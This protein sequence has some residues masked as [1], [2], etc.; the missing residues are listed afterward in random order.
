MTTFG[1]QASATVTLKPTATPTPTPTTTAATTWRFVNL[2]FGVDPFDSRHSLIYGEVINASGVAQEI[3]DFTGTF[4][5]AQGQIVA[6]NDRV[7]AYWPLTVLPPGGQMPFELQVLEA[8]GLTRADLGVIAT[9]RDEAP[10]TDF[11]FENVTQV[12]NNEFYCLRGQLRNPGNRLTEYLVIAGLLYDAQNNLVR[13]ADVSDGPPIFAMGDR[14][15]SFEI[16]LA[17]PY[18]GAVRHELRAW[19]R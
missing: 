9:P 18:P 16:C 1:P 11:L 5:N 4:Y 15:K 10:H 2:T 7:R 13:F 6:G 19:G 3:S 12:I 17:P 14:L 8:T